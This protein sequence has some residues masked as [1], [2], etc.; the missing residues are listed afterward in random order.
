MSPREVALRA[1]RRVPARMFGVWMSLQPA[2]AALIG[3]V[4][5]GQRLS[6]AEW[7]G[8]NEQSAT[9]MNA[10]LDYSHLTAMRAPKP[11]L[12]IFNEKNRLGAARNIL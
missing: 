2:V 12:L 4:V 6:A 3:L 7:A 5:L 9:D 11:T 10:V 1:L 8:D